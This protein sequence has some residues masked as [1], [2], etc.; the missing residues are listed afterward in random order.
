M[1]ARRSFLAGLGA[2]LATPAIVHAGNLMPVRSIERFTRSGAVTFYVNHGCEDSSR[3]NGLSTLQPFRTVQEAL[4]AAERHKAVT[5]QLMASK[6]P[7]NLSFRVWPQQ[8]VT[9]RGMNELRM[10]GG[11]E[12]AVNVSYPGFR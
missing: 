9:L 5:V 7:E 10:H 11:G 1:I 4:K 3:H 2:M 6:Y 12:R 8:S